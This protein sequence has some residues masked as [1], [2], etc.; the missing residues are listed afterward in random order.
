M[1]KIFIIES[2]INYLHSL[3]A[4]FR[5]GGFSVETNSGNCE[6]IDLIRQIE[7]FMPEFIVLDLFLINIKSVA[8]LSKIPVFVYGSDNGENA[9]AKCLAQ[10]AKYYFTKEE[11]NCE[12]VFEKVKKIIQNQEI[13]KK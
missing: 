1:K 4:K 6:E 8:H 10:G 5:L 13:L 11:L 12:G 2:N 7:A 9:E 3:E